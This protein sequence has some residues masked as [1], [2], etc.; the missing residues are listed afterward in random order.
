MAN[1]SNKRKRMEYWKEQFNKRET[2]YREIRVKTDCREVKTIQHNTMYSLTDWNENR[3]ALENYHK[4]KLVTG[5]AE[6]LMTNNLV[7]ITS[8]VD[9][10]EEV[11]RLRAV[12][13]VVDTK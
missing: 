5:L 12:L 9:C 11:V 3:A 6:Y 2:P 7:E 10:D 8:D 13:R 1:K 4:M